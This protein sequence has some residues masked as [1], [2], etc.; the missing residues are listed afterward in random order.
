M[1]DASKRAHEACPCTF[2]LVPYHCE[3]D[4]RLVCRC[5]GQL[6]IYAPC[7][8]P[9]HAAIDALAQPE[10]VEDGEV[11]AAEKAALWALS[12]CAP[13]SLSIDKR[14]VEDAIEHLASLARR[15]RG[16][17]LM[18]NDY[19]IANLRAAIEACGYATW[20][21]DWF[22]KSPLMVLQ[23]GDWM[24]EIYLMLPMVQHAPNQTPQKLIEEALA[25]CAPLS[26]GA[27][28]LLKQIVEKQ[29]E[30]DAL[31]FIAETAPESYLQSEL[32]RL[33]AAVESA[34]AEGE[35]K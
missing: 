30:D 25:R 3:G 33:H 11:E 22:K 6:P 1:N 20:H 27:R 23:N 10:P 13:H 14:R 5:R 28:A 19:Q 26:E 2:T 34:L 24:G 35:G 15:G 29:A 8:W 4:P 17:A 12:C 9:G 32:R 7:K 18:L 31:W 16:H 21:K